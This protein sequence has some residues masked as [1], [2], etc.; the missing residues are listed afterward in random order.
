MEWLRDWL[1]P[2]IGGAVMGVVGMAM[3][4]L[5][6]G[7]ANA[8]PADH[9]RIRCSRWAMGILAALCAAFAAFVAWA[10]S[11]QPHHPV[12]PILATIGTLGALYCAGWLDPAFDVVWD[13]YGIEGPTS[14]RIWPLGPGRTRMGYGAIT[15]FGLDAGRS[16]FVEDTKGRRVLWSFLY[17]GFPR[18]MQ[19][20]EARRPDLFPT[21]SPEPGTH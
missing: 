6:Q 9:G 18:L 2:L 15:G 20:I 16:W 3:R 14:Y 7:A 11:Y 13:D 17:L 1:G 19:E 12:P 21:I 5:V 4:A 10:G 8:E